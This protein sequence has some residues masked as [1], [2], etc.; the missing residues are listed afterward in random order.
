MTGARADCLHIGIIRAAAAFRGYPDNVL[1]WILDV[2]CLAVNAVLRVD[3]Q[4]RIAAIV[5]S[6]DLVDAGRAIALFRRIIEREVC[7]NWYRCILEG[8][9]GRLIFLMVGC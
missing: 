2:A 7:V 3:L 6:H 8:Q 9:M 5:V 4:S 1:G